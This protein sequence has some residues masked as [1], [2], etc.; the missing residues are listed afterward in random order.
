MNLSFHSKS[1]TP[2]KVILLVIVVLL[3]CLFIYYFALYKKSVHPVETYFTNRIYDLH[4]AEQRNKY[5]VISVPL[6][7]LPYTI[8]YWMNIRIVSDVN[9]TLAPKLLLYVGDQE[10]T[11]SILNHAIE[12]DETI[13]GYQM[14]YESYMNNKFYHNKTGRSNRYFRA[15]EWVQYT[16][17][18]REK[19]MNIYIN[20]RLQEILL[21]ER[22]WHQIANPC[23][24]YFVIPP[25]VAFSKN[26]DNPHK[27][28]YSFEWY[29]R[30]LTNGEIDA[31]YKEQRIELDQ[32]LEERRE[33]VENT[34]DN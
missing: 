30:V 1:W 10:G 28:L 16:I 31:K 20:G 6:T 8:S 22:T 26:Y 19:S 11:Y 7:K 32:L 5:R 3:L 29:N 12:Y 9:S 33:S 13:G 17:T 2:P 25:Y 24:A 23:Y 34:C 4:N 15:N 14:I 27:S 18:F 21:Y